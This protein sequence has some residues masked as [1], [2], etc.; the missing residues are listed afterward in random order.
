MKIKI[1]AVC[2]AVMAI[3]SCM[4][5]TAFAEDI[6]VQNGVTYTLGS[7]K[8]VLAVEYGVTYTITADTS[9][10][11]TT[12]N[13]TYASGYRELRFTD[14]ICEYT[15]TEENLKSIVFDAPSDTPI[16]IT[17]SWPQP[18]APGLM[19]FLSFVGGAIWG[20][21]SVISS[22]IAGNALL[23]FTVGFLFVGGCV[24]IFGRLL[25]KS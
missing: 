17:V 23:F 19:D 9:Y 1:F 8:V 11:P 21:I 20:Q 18:P 16:E 25:R 22:I 3:M 2:L 10:L 15:C 4:C 13:W 5:V 7:E 14:G 24:A 6:Y 12:Y